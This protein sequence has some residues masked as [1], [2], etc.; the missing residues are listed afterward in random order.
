MIFIFNFSSEEYLFETLCVC[1]KH[2]YNF[3]LFVYKK[4]IFT[5]YINNLIWLLGKHGKQTF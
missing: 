5:F 4:F 2:I 1:E 3:Y